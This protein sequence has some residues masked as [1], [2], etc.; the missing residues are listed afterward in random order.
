MTKHILLV[1]DN[2]TIQRAHAAFAKKLGV[3]ATIVMSGQ[4]A[5]DLLSKDAVDVVFMDMEMPL[6]NGVETTLALRRMG[7]AT[8]IVAVTG[9]DNQADQERCRQAGMNGY[10]VKPMKIDSMQRAL[11]RLCSMP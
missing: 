7:V 9:N 5:I 10:I 3:T 1:D 2:P 11:D 6:M 4:E 8:P